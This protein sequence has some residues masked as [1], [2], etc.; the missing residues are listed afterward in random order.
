M[1]SGK[2]EHLASI[3]YHLLASEG[4]H[5]DGRGVSE[6]DRGAATCFVDFL[7]KL[8]EGSDAPPGKA[9]QKESSW[10]EDQMTPEE[11]ISVSLMWIACCTAVVQDRLDAAR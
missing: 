9:V 6:S 4:L 11:G 2:T 10:A 8:G 5:L 3:S 1:S 7:A